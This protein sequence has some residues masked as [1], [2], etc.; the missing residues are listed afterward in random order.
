MEQ[1]VQEGHHELV[2]EAQDG[3]GHLS[4]VNASAN[5]HEFRPLKDGAPSEP[6]R[7]LSSRYVH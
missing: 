6:R 5:R 3:S 4:Q 1:A 2:A 7:P